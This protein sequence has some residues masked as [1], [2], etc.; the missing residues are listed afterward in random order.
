MSWGCVCGLCGISGSICT[1][2]MGR[3]GD[4]AGGWEMLLFEGPALLLTL[5]AAVVRF[6]VGK[7]LSDVCCQLALTA[8][9]RCG[10]RSWCCSASMGS[11]SFITLSS[12]DLAISMNSPAFS[13]FMRQLEVVLYKFMTIEQSPLYR[14]AVFELLAMAA[15][16]LMV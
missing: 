3:G 1:F 2:V 5:L 15:Q 10:L 16:L 7:G 13:P 4:T 12:M 6:A 11:M 9:S 8:S 14:S